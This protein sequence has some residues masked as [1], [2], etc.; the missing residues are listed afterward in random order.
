MPVPRAANKSTESCSFS[1]ERVLAD[2][3]LVLRCSRAND[4]LLALIHAIVERLLGSLATHV[5]RLLACMLTVAWC[6]SGDCMLA[7]S[8]KRSM[9][10]DRAIAR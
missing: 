1:V 8:M 4:L 9:H 5:E 2:L 7:S 3:A 10:F 6:L